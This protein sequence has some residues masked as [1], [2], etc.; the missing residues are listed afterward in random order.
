MSDELKET[1]ISGICIVLIVA[2]I[3]GTVCAMIICDIKATNE[4]NLKELQYKYQGENILE[5]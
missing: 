2:I 3:F 5:D 1:L 4:Y